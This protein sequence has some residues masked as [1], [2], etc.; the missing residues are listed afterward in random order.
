MGSTHIEQLAMLTRLPDAARRPEFKTALLHISAEMKER[1]HQ[2]RASSIGFFAEAISVFSRIRGK[3]HASVRMD[4]LFDSASFLFIHGRPL[5]ALQGATELSQ[6]ARTCRSKHWLR[7][8]EM[9]N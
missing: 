7:K 9:L 2:G 3:T 8:A 5:D 1:I 6:L 4:C